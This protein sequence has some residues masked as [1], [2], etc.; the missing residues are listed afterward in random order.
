ML[1]P[2]RPLR[3]AVLCSHRAPGLLYLLNRSPDRGVTYEVVCVVSSDRA[4][5]EEVRVERRGIPTFGHPIH[6]FY[7]ERGLIGV[8]DLDVRA[9]YDA[10][11][12]KRLD[13][14]TP[15]LVLL[16]GYLYLVTAPLLTAF[17]SRILNLHFSDLTIRTSDGHSR[18]PGLRAVRDALLA[19]LSETRATVHLVNERLDDGPPIVRSWPFPVAGLIEDLRTQDA[20]EVIRAY[21]FAHEQWMLRTVSGPLTAAALRLVSTGAV[22]LRELSESQEATPWLLDRLGWLHAPEPAMVAV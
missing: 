8:G 4:F 13:E 1:T 21:T 22:D 19:G 14:Y 7:A 2:H 15:D 6:D 17:P 16:D 18:F 10:A 9:E 12:L 20:S 3:I 11:T 5:A